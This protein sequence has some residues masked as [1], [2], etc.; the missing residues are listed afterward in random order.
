MSSSHMRNFY[1]RL[2]DNPAQKLDVLHQLSL[3]YKE[4]LFRSNCRTDGAIKCTLNFL[5][6]TET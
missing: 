3:I 5:I 2:F 4:L 1:L 6:G